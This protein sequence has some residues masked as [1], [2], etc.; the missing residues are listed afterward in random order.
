MKIKVKLLKHG[1][2]RLMNDFPNELCALCVL[3]GWY[4]AEFTRQSS[5][6]LARYARFRRPPASMPSARRA[7]AGRN[8]RVCTALGAV[9]AVIEGR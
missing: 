6:D 8:Q 2:Q 9:S 1:V 4:V 7:I 3:C 5:S